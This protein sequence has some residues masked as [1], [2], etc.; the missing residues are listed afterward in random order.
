LTGT[1]GEKGWPGPPGDNGDQ[2]LG[3]P[4]GPAGEAGPPGNPGQCVCQNTELFVPDTGYAAPAPS[5]GAPAP[6]Y[7]GQSYGGRLRDS[8][9]TDGDD[10]GTKDVAGVPQE[11]R[12]VLKLDTKTEENSSVVRSKSTTSEVDDRLHVQ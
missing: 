8:P 4:D 1:Q 6:S 2:G 9:L 10:A 3:G 7:G 11:R 5:Y 12:T